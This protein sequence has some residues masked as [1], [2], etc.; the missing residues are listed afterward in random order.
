MKQFF[1]LLKLIDGLISYQNRI[2]HLNG[3]FFKLIR[4]VF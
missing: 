1:K 2:V 4:L 3:G